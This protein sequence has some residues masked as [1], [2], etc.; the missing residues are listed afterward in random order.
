MH[1]LH[2]NNIKYPTTVNESYPKHDKN[3]A[4]DKNDIKMIKIRAKS[5]QAILQE[6]NKACQTK[7]IKM[8]KMIKTGAY[9]CMYIYQ[10]YVNYINIHMNNN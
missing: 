2:K 6:N 9:I 5:M 8:I 10:K 1:F 3:D 4:N 7:T